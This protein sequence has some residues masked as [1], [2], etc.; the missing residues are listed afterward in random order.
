LANFTTTDFNT[1]MTVMRPYLASLLY[2]SLGI[3]TKA[4][5]LSYTSPI[6]SVFVGIFLTN[7]SVFRKKNGSNS[8]IE[9]ASFWTAL[10]ATPAHYS[11][12]KRFTGPYAISPS[13]TFKAVLVCRWSSPVE[14][15]Q[16]KSLDGYESSDDSVI[17]NV[18]CCL[19]EFT[20]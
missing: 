6:S 12:F 10:Q 18:Q 16:V 8:T 7:R 20:C 17:T 1:I 14:R 15:S 9:S 3:R 2:R 4:I 5:L 13:S 19:H 11:M